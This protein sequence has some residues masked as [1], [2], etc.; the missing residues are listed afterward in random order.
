MAAREATQTSHMR[1]WLGREQDV[2]DVLKTQH[3]SDCM[4]RQCP[5]TSE[6]VRFMGVICPH[7]SSLCPRARDRTLQD[8]P[9]VIGCPV[10]LGCPDLYVSDRAGLNGLDGRRHAWLD[11]G[12]PNLLTQSLFPLHNIYPVPHICLLYTS[13]SPR[14]S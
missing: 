1:T 2:N 11:A 8:T 12:F 10:R 9:Y 6:S 13:P 14:D 3:L 4:H 7:M 5:Q